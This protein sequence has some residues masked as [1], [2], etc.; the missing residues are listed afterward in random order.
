[1]L[2]KT[3]LTHVWHRQGCLEEARL[4]MDEQRAQLREAGASRGEAREEVWKLAEEEFPP[5]E[6]DG[7]G[8]ADSERAVDGE[9]TDADPERIEALLASREGDGGADVIGDAL[10]AYEHLDDP[11]AAERAPSAGAFSLLRWARRSP[12]RFYQLVVSK[13]LSAR[14]PSDAQQ[15]AAEA[16]R[17]RMEL[18]NLE[19]M[20]HDLM[21]A[22]GG[23]RV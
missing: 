8:L 5:L 22:A 14:G 10:W 7:E 12:D 17:D 18:N 1:M 2:S 21:S 19:E 11:R 9:L 16:V 6:D 23:E 13:V 20:M 4:F 3:Q 15:Q